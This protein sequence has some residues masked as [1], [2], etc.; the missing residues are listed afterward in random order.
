MPGKAGW[1]GPSRH[2]LD[3]CSS[4]APEREAHRRPYGFYGNLQARLSRMGAMEGGAPDMNMMGTQIIGK[5]QSGLTADVHNGWWVQR[6]VAT[7]CANISAG[8]IGRASCRERVC[9]SGEI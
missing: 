7:R 4:F 2:T 8:E 3:A 9:Q 1:R 5:F 6:V